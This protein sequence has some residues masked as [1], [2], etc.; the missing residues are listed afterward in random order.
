MSAH[1]PI[2]NAIRA[3]HAALHLAT[4][5]VLWVIDPEVIKP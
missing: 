1:S 2:Q 3:L 5:D 4:V